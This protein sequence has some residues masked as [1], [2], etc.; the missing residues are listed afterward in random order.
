MA[1]VGDLVIVTWLDAAFSTA[2]Y[3]LANKI[4]LVMQTV[5]WLLRNDEEGVVVI[6]EIDEQGENRRVTEIPRP[7]VEEVKVVGKRKRK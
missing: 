5:G 6:G 7:Y 2:G 3:N 1:K 4:G